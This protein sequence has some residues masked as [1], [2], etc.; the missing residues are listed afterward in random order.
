MS[1]LSWVVVIMI[2]GGAVITATLKYQER[3]Y[4]KDL[5]E[6]SAE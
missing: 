1:A 5:E 4:L 6:N 3:K 2:S